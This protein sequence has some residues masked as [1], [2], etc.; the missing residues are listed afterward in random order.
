MVERFSWGA[1]R[2]FFPIFQER[3][4]IYLDSAATTLTPRPVIDAQVRYYTVERATVGRSSYQAAANV[5]RLAEQTREQLATRL[6]LP[7]GGAVVFCAGAT[8]ALNMVAAAVS[9]KAGDNVVTTLLE[10]HSNLLPWMVVR[11]RGVELRLARPAPDGLL[12]VEDVLKWVDGNTRV[13]AVTHASNV[14][15]VSPPVVDICAEVHRRDILC[16][17]DGAQSFGHTAVDLTEVGCD[18]FAASAHKAFGPTGIGL[19]AL[20]SRALERL[21]PPV[22]GGGMVESVDSD[23]FRPK[24]APGGWEAGTP[25]V[26]GMVSWGA[27]LP[28]WELGVSREALGYVDELAAALIDGLRRIDGVTVPGPAE[29]SAHHGIVPFAI[30]GMGPHRVGTVL[31]EVFGIMVRAGQYCAMPLHREVL[32]LPRGSVRVSLAPYNSLKEIQSLVEAVRWIAG[33]RK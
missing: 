28:V 30:G 13:V 14:L 1:F 10:H 26:A 11:S 19:L 20:S 33:V 31:D 18:A 12:Q 29:A 25:H 3:T 22:V 21:S 8:S 16:V 5:S 23:G 9:W 2:E 6:N 32:G 4:G 24:P 7:P 15:G 17:V 27:A